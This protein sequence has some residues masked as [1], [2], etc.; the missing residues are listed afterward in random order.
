MKNRFSYDMCK[1]LHVK[2]KITK[3]NNIF[4][5]GCGFSWNYINFVQHTA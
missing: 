2:I 5:L 4:R 1:K 3:I